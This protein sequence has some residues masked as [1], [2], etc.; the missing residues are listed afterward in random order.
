MTLSKNN[1]KKNHN[2]AFNYNFGNLASKAFERVFIIMN[3]PGSADLNWTALKK[4]IESDRAC[5]IVT[6]GSLTYKHLLDSENLIYL[7]CDPINEWFLINEINS[8]NNP[9]LEE[10]ALKFP[11]FDKSNLN[12]LEYDLESCKELLKMKKTKIAIQS[13]NVKNINLNCDRFITFK[14]NF[15]LNVMNLM[16][17][18]WH[19]DGSEPVSITK[20]YGIRSWPVHSRIWPFVKSFKTISRLWYL[21]N[22]HQTPNTFYR[23]LDLAS[24]LNTREICFV[25][26]NSQMLQWLNTEN[27]SRDKEILLRYNYFFSE[28]TQELR[29]RKF[30][31]ILRDAY[32]SSQYIEMLKNIFP[33]IDYI[34]LEQTLCYLD[35]FS[36]DHQHRYMSSEIVKME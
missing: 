35:Y 23:A 4:E 11:W 5:A 31:Y 27:R 2:V 16:M 7:V 34:C 30:E 13:N 36:L 8:L 19:M 28:V 17:Y 21:M 12:A 6:N 33:N 1:F 9:Q 20:R 18:S 10:F 24:N 32:Y 29:T 26:K 15:F 25:G 3:G 14:K 22:F